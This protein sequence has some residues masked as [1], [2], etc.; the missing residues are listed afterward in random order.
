MENVTKLFGVSVKNFSSKLDFYQINK[1]AVKRGYF[2]MPDACNTDTL[3]FLTHIYEDYNKTFYKEWNDIISKSRFELLADQVLHYFTTYGT[4]FTAEP[5]VP[6]DGAEA[7]DLKELKVIDAITVDELA[8]RV[9]KM[10]YSGIALKSHTIECLMEILEHYH[11]L[12]TIKV[13]NI[14]NKEFMARYCVQTRIM[15]LNAED[16]LRCLVYAATNQTMIIK[17]KEI[18]HQIKVSS[19]KLGDYIKTDDDYKKLSSLFLRH[20]AIFL[21]FKNNQS[22]ANAFV[23]NKLRK[24][25]KKYHEPFKAPFWSEYIAN[26]YSGKFGNTFGQIEGVTKSHFD[27]LTLFKAVSLIQTMSYQARALSIN[28]YNIRNGKAYVVNNQNEVNEEYRKL[29]LGEKDVFHFFDSRNADVEKYN[30]VTDL[31][32]SNNRLGIAMG[33]LKDYIKA[34]LSKKA[35]TIRIPDNI[36]YALPTSEKNFIGAMPFG[37]K[38]TMQE[39]D[40]IVGIYWENAWGANDLDLSMTNI[41]GHK[42]GWNGG[43]NDDGW[44]YSGDMTNAIHGASELL[45]AKKN[46]CNGIVKVNVYYRNKDNG[47]F[48][49]MIAN[50]QIKDGDYKRGYMVDPNNIVYST[51]IPFESRN[52]LNLG[53][54]KDNTFYFN[55]FSLSN[56]AV[57]YSGCS[58]KDYLEYGLEMCDCFEYLTEELL[59]DCGFTIVKDD[60][61]EVELDFTKPTLDMF[62]DLMSKE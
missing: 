49:F 2:V 17:S 42:V 62:M 10:V 57:S 14:K 35:T 5:F 50:E 34:E 43:Y 37:T 53:I 38:V 61:T 41:Q 36:V 25:A 1:M 12:D 13:E 15:P 60:N 19:L 51:E 54:M 46:A 21:A 6:N 32:V 16:F 39:T 27:T 44:I 23:V 30:Q 48:H 52:E 22:N 3:D 40:K 7:P 58:T 59:L 18:L 33:I 28:V 29:L 9:Q 55:N 24:Y 8:A 56:S 47:K 31:I 11:I 20:K 4:N 45:Y 26:V